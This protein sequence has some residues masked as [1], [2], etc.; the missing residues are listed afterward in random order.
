M[1]VTA[2]GVPRRRV[3]TDQQRMRFAEAALTIEMDT[4]DVR[5]RSHDCTHGV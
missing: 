4:V 3:S 5:E 2:F 1:D